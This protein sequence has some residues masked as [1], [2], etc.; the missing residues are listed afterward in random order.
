M[1]VEVDGV[2]RM[3]IPS[4]LSLSVLA[5]F[6]LGCSSSPAAN[7]DRDTDAGVNRSAST[8]GA[9]ANG[10][11]TGGAT[12]AGGTSNSN[13]GTGLVATAI[14]A[15]VQDTCALLRSASIR[16]WGDNDYG[17][18]GNGTTVSSAIV[19]MSHES[20]YNL[21]KTLAPVTLSLL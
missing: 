18:L 8:G 9:A 15:G 6:S 11:L 7:T 12:P 10:A 1:R 3:S 5:I 16:C 19:R 4:P 14:A 13:P 21:L 20:I 2:N 17:E